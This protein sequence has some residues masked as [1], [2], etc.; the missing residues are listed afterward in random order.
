VKR[1]GWSVWGILIAGAVWAGGCSSSGPPLPPPEP[2]PEWL[3]DEPSKVFGRNCAVGR[4]GATLNM[5]DARRNAERAARVALAEMD[6]VH[7]RVMMLD[8]QR[9]GTVGSQSI[10]QVSEVT[11]EGLV[12]HSTVLGHWYDATGVVSQGATRTTYAVVCIE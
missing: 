9:S 1:N 7:V 4:S 10:R 2:P 6:K 8:D 5:E 3:L 12:E 11:G